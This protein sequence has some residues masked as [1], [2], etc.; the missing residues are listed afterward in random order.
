MLVQ[1][2]LRGNFTILA[3]IM[4]GLRVVSSEVALPPLRSRCGRK[5]LQFHLS[6]PLLYFFFF[7]EILNQQVL[8][9]MS[10]CLDH[11]YERI[12]Q[13]ENERHT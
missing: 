2:C 9:R 13:E 3:W 7:R 11:R 5:E 12:S 8:R 4:I 6:A 10:F 1:L